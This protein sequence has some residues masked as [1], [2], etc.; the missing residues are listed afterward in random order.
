[1]RI[2][3]VILLAILLRISAF[4]QD[5]PIV[6]VSGVV[7]VTDT[8]VP[9]PYVS[10]YRHRDYRGTFT[11]Y[12]GYFS[13][14]A[15]VGDTLRFVRIGLKSSYFVVPYDTL[16]R[17]SVV[18]LMDEDTLM[19]PTVNILPYPAPHRLRQEM[20]ALDLPGDGYNRFSRE[21][22]DPKN[23]DGLRNFADD[24]YNEGSS[25]LSAR[26]SNSFKS[27]GNLLDAAAWRKFMKALKR[28]DY[29][30]Q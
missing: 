23:Y 13:L 18:Q 10:I 24:A 1:M 29:E 14:P 15:Q 3:T 30:K 19:L 5:K 28:G 8:L 25:T 27:G 2:L 17:I 16:N 12:N 26:Y 7:V 6:Q 20:L 21:S 11:D 4:A 9:V 22:L